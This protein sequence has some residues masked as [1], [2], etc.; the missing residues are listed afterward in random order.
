MLRL[1]KLVVLT[2]FFEQAKILLTTNW[3]QKTKQE[4]V[5]YYMICVPL[6]QGC[7][8][9]QKTTASFEW[10]SP[11]PACDYTNTE[12]QNWVH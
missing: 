5:Y 6:F 11:W 3:K 2:R 4:S 7:K 9:A 10:R 1:K 8:V 12:I